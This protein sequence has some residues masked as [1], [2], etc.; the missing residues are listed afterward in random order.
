MTK[1]KLT[2]K[3]LRKAKGVSKDGVEVWFTTTNSTWDDYDLDSKKIGDEIEVEIAM[4]SYNR[5]YVERLGDEKYC[6][7][8]KIQNMKLQKQLL[9]KQIASL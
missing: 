8:M 5:P 9:M 4:S 1:V 6:I 7:E 2:E 3:G